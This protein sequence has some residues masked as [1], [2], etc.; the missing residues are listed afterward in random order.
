MAVECY[1]EDSVIDTFKSNVEAAKRGNRD[2]A[3]RLMHDINVWNNSGDSCR[4]QQTPMV[5]D[6]LLQ[7]GFEIV[8]QHG[9][10]YEGRVYGESPVLQLNESTQRVIERVLQRK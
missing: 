2:A 6:A 3:E 1:V 7:D 10:S 9:G 5:A 4:D 8:D